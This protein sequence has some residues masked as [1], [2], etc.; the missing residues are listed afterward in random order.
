MP[1][2]PLLLALLLVAAGC[3]GTPEERPLSSSI[4]WSPCPGQAVLECGRVE[5]DRIAGDAESGS[6]SIAVARLPATDPGRRIGSLLL[7]FGGPGS[8]GI[9]LLSIVGRSIVPDEIAARF[10]LVAFDQR[11]VGKTVPVDCLD[12]ALLDVYVSEEIPP[13]D[14]GSV[15]LA[16]A[17]ASAQAFATAC[18][19]R[20][21]PEQ[22]AD[23]STLATVADL[24]AIRVAVGDRRLNYLGFSYGGMLGALYADRYPELVRAMVLD[25]AV[26]PGI[27]FASRLAEQAI[28][29]EVGLARFL[30]DC[31]RRPACPFAADPEIGA[32]DAFDALMARL[33]ETP[34]VL[35]DG[36]LLN[37]GMALSGVMAGLYARETWGTIAAGLARADEGD[38]TILASLA[39]SYV[40]RAEDGSYENNSVEANTAINCVDYAAERDPA[41]YDR[42]VAET[43][44]SAPRF[45]SLLAYSGLTCAAWP[46]AANPVGR[47]SGE[48]APAILVIGTTGDPAAPFSWS[49]RLADQLESGL[50]L[51]YRSAGHTAVGTGDPCVD[52][53]VAAYLVDLNVPGPGAIC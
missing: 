21:G 5:A 9:E 35:S 37:E 13:R 7:H 4:A 39:D 46:V 51:T 25:G 49:V 12:D 34:I 52:A 29:F 20:S 8:S 38:G 30:V 50:L 40:G 44:V 2:L 32:S 18:A 47:V 33:R 22:L 1:R 11:G 42:L 31:D 10:D 53:A 26:E 3:V 23:V 24:E 41:A 36:R 43:R 17:W 27:S 16:K 28:A 15:D 6:I 45:A 19:A 48:G 14:P